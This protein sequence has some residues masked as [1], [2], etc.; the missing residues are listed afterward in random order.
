MGLNF[1]SP[2]MAVFYNKVNGEVDNALGASVGVAI[3]L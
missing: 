1:I 3:S 2:G